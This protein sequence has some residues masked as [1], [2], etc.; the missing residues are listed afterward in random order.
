MCSCKIFQLPLVFALS[1]SLSLN[2]FFV[3]QTCNNEIFQI[4]GWDV[5]WACC[6]EIAAPKVFSPPLWAPH[7][8]E[9]CK[10]TVTVYASGKIIICLLWSLKDSRKGK[11]LPPGGQRGRSS[12]QWDYGVGGNHHGGTEKM[13]MQTSEAI[14]MLVDACC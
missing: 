3:A 8:L 7:Q 2:F 9:L 11:L 14:C 1:L 6:Q 13:V 4:K 10:N 5:V 12:I